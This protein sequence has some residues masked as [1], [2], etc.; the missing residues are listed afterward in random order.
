LS[1]ILW[2]RA[3]VPS[4]DDAAGDVTWDVYGAALRV[5]RALRIPVPDQDLVELPDPRAYR[6]LSRAGL[7]LTA[8][9]LQ[10]LDV[11]RPFVAG[12]PYGVGVYCAIEWG[13][14]DYN[15]ARQMVDSPPED[16]AACYKALRSA[17]QYF[18][19][20]PNVPAAQLAIFL[21]IM[22]PMTVFN[23]SRLGCLHALDQAEHD[24]D[25]HVVQAAL[26]CSAFSLEDP[27]LTARTRRASG[28]EAVLC[29]GAAC[30]V[31][32]PDGHYTDWRATRPE[33]GRRVFGIASHLV[34]LAL[35]RESDAH[36]PGPVRPRG[37]RD[38][39]GAQHRAP[40]TLAHHVPEPGSRG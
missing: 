37:Q 22:G 20:L 36:R 1:T 17:K 29:E 26:V 12:D 8:V 11:V 39:G 4:S 13:P 9:G 14:N 30:L 2:K 33:D 3:L 34:G 31:L 35:R 19:M 5:P 18:K 16:F 25:G 32:V 10:S 27:L 28:T 21:G 15:C 40:L 24:L 23:H 6:S 38:Q 7:L